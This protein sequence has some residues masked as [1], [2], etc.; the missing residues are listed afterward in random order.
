MSVS[1]EFKLAKD[2]L[3]TFSHSEFSL[4]KHMIIKIDFTCPS[5]IYIKTGEFVNH[6]SLRKV[7]HRCYKLHVPIYS[8]F[9]SIICVC[10][11][12]NAA[13]WALI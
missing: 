6:E 11:N 1:V 12:L 10:M 4:I 13:V 3:S 8:L 7:I 2:V 9:I 5:L